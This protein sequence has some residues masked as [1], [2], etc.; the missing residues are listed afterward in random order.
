[1]RDYGRDKGEIWEGWSFF[2]RNFKQLSSS[3]LKADENVS[4][5]PR[6]VSSSPVLADLIDDRWEADRPSRAQR[7]L[8]PLRPRWKILGAF[9]QLRAVHF[10]ILGTF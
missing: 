7:F 10:S 8:A 6:A 9:F 1:M 2:A 3:N 4:R 5:Y